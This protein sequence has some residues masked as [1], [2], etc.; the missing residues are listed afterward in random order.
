[1]DSPTYKPLLSTGETMIIHLPELLS[2]EQTGGSTVDSYRVEIRSI[3]A[4]QWTVV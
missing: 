3:S 1:M 2:Y 4:G